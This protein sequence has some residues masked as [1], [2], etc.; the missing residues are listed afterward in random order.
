MLLDGLRSGEVLALQL[1]DLQMADGQMRVLG[2]GNKKRVLPLPREIVNVLSTLA[3]EVLEK[4]LKLE[5]PLT[6]MR[7]GYAIRLE[8]IWF[9]PESHCPRY[10]S[11]MRFQILAPMGHS[12]IHTTGART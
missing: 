9:A 10:N 7:I 8:R 1:D 11:S 4:Y 5:R 12:Q 6:P 3:P 2:K